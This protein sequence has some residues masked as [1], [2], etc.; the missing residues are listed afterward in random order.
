MLQDSTPISLITKAYMTSFSDDEKKRRESALRNKD[1]Y[2]GRQEQYL[3]L[4]N[5]DMEPITINILN[6]IISKRSSLLY[7]RPLVREFI[8]P[9]KSVKYLDQLYYDIKIDSILHKVDLSAELTGTCLLYVGFDENDNIQLIPYDASDISAV[10]TGIDDQQLEALSLIS[11]KNDM[12]NNGG[13]IQVKRVIESQIWTNNYIYK[14]KDNTN[15]GNVPNELGYIPFV[16][17]KAQEVIN[18]YLGH[19][20]TTSVRQLNN[21]LN[22]VTTNL[23]YMI[24]MQSATPIVLTGFSN[25]EA[26]SIHPG[27]AINLPAGTTAG[28][29]SL[30]PK[31]NE[32]LD[33]IKYLED[34]VYET[35]S[36][37][38]ISVIGNIGGTSSGVELMIKWA[39]LISV[40]KEK[41]IR[42]QKYELNLANMILDMGGYE[43]IEDI[44]VN[45]PEDNLLPIDPERDKLEQD[46]KLGIKTPIDEI[47]KNNP[48]LTEDEAEAEFLVNLDTNN[49]L[50]KEG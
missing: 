3:T 39:P 41:A 43:L 38:K 50:N 20:P 40:F 7:N 23:G 48:S 10:S 34:K 22:Q 35:S 31:I 26:I 29:L 27:T 2:Y 45:Y 37:P 46:I 1:F 5:N 12:I 32:T 30:N 11:I 17:F 42:Y 9:S 44:K 28:A 36:I 15:M 6:P 4:I 16:S 14:Y 24:K 33:M 8:G 18:Q 25:G 47:L 21:Y 13:N 19:A 49:K